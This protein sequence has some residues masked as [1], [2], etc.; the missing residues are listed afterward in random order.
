MAQIG[1]RSRVIRETQRLLQRE[2]SER[3]GISGSTI[4]KVETGELPRPSAELV[5]KL[6]KGL[7]VHPGELFR[8]PEDPFVDVEGR[9]YSPLGTE[10]RIEAFGTAQGSGFA[11]PSMNDALA[12]LRALTSDWERGRLGDAALVE[13][14]GQVHQRLQ[15][16]VSSAGQG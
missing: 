12:Q 15:K 4:S 13:G 9:Q 8:D 1:R 5:E 16:L 14:V 2:V 7:G 6:A 3:S 11:S 10:V